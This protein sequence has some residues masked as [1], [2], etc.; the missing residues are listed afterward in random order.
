[1][2][3]KVQLL[4]GAAVLAL[5]CYALA[6]PGPRRAHAQT[7]AAAPAA[8]PQ[9]PAPQPPATPT[10]AD[11]STPGQ[12]DAPPADEHMERVETNLVNVL[13]NVVDKERRFV[14]TLARE[15]V[16]VFE[17]NT[18]QAIT[19][20]EQETDLPL[21]LAILVDVSLS[22]LHTLPDEKA[23]AHLFVQSIV[24]PE[25]DR[26][27]VVSFARDATI[28][29]DLTDNLTKLQHAIE[30]IQIAPPFTE[31][32]EGNGGIN[33][34][35]PAPAT[36]PTPAAAASPAANAPADNRPMTSTALWDTIW[37]A[38]GEIMAQTPEGTRRALILL[39]DGADSS[40]QL[41]RDDA[42][43]AAIKNNTV[44]YSIGIGDADFDEGALKKIAE[45]TGGRAFFPEDERQLRV[46]FA[47]IQQELRTQ[48]LISYVPTNKAHDGT[49][50][51]LRLDVVNR[52]LQKQKLKLTYRRG[53][54][55]NPPA[56][57]SEQPRPPRQRLPQPPPRRKR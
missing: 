6:L 22:Q 40:S 27:A 4:V 3:G 50:R 11:T 9:A 34:T 42:V 47:Q 23:A 52:E 28:E 8:P 16:R 51:Q 37:A 19:N 15:D 38:S 53:Y 31:P 29:Q 1:M 10:P 13:F 39:S 48:Y 25:R 56:R 46:A 26:V 36:T 21:S 55:A 43:E 12:A 30:V 24:R 49:F 7:G 41:K 2:R 45:R 14:T 57:T 17:D 5:V 33:D 54:Y 20:F 18:E 44:V 32:A 35:P